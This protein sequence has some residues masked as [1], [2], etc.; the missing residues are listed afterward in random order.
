MNLFFRRLEQNRI[1]Q[2]EANS[3]SHMPK[4]VRLDLSKNNI[5]S[6]HPETFK[7]LKQLNSL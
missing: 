6:A 1:T 3:F 4:L 5:I 2:L 7:G